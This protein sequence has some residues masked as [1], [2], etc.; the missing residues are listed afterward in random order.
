MFSLFF[1]GNAREN[2]NWSQSVLQV[3]RDV[4]K[5]EPP[6]YLVLI[7]STNNG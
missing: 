5:T 4:Q 7:Y 2:V 3:Q 1:F 6:Y